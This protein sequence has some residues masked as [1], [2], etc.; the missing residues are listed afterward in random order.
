MSGRITRKK[1]RSRENGP[2]EWWLVSYSR[3]S[4]CSDSRHEKEIQRALTAYI[5]AGEAMDEMSQGWLP[6]CLK[7]E[8]GIPVLQLHCGCEAGLMPVF[9]S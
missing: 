4:V 1:D 8:S 6:G 9:D 2:V 5:M 3:E 7:C